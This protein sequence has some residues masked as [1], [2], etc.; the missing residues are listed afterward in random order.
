MYRKSGLLNWKNESYPQ[1][2][3]KMWII[4]RKPIFSTTISRYIPHRGE[5]WRKECGGC[6]KKCGKVD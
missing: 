6:G 3:H 4:L 2:I 5:F 1:V